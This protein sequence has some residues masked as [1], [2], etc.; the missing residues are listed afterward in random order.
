[1]FLI[2]NEDKMGELKKDSISIYEKMFSNVMNVGLPSITENTSDIKK[3]TGANHYTSF[4]IYYHPNPDTPTGFP[5]IRKDGVRN[6]D[7]SNISDAKHLSDLNNS[8]L[9]LCILYYFTK[10]EKYSN[11]AVEIINKFFINPETKMNPDLTYSGLVVGNSMDDLRIRGAIIDT[12][13]LCLLPDLIELIK[14]SPNW[15]TE[16]E[17]GMVAWFESLS[18]WLKTNPRAILQSSYSHNIKTS[19][20]SQLCS[21]L[22][23]CGKKDEAKNYLENN[24]RDLLSA[25]IDSEGKQVLEMKRVK[26]RHYSNFNITMLN[27]LAK[28]SK[29]L[30]INIWN[31]ED[32]NGR[33]SIKKAMKY[34]CHFYL[35]PEEWNTSD[36]INDVTML[37]STRLWLKDGVELY[38]DL[39]LHQTYE[40]VKMN[41]SNNNVII[42][43]NFISLPS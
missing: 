25:Q 24:I 28:I 27:R 8:L 32:E 13:G 40:L 2:F 20:V 1:M 4:A 7:L 30:G 39:I 31:Y 17:N 38:D 9:Q 18:D 34:M 37:V 14:N 41:V 12:N 42:I 29:S 35:N 6:S 3:V 16:L 36:E 21:Y 19:Y 15:T 11:R 23:A 22:C 5:Y 26:N 43:P 10:S 33:G